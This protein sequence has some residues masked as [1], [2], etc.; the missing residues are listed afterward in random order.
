MTGL[1]I[2][3][4]YL[5]FISLGLP[6]SLLGSAWPS[7]YESMHSTITG[8]GTLAML[9]SACTI[10]SSLMA[11]RV[12]HRFGT[13]R[14]TTCSVAM[15]AC[16]LFGFSVSRS[17]LQL[18]FWC[19]PY[20]LGAGAVDSALNNYV[21]LHYSSR[22]M[23]WL[24]CMWGIG[25]SVG[26]WIMGLCLNRGQGW[27]MGYRI[28]GVL[29]VI[30]TVVLVVSFPLW[31]HASETEE[32]VHQV[33]PLKEAIRLPGAKP[34]LIAFLC[35]CGLEMTTGLWAASWLVTERGVNAVDAASYASLFYLGIT[36]GRA[37]S[38][39]ISERAGDE[40]MIRLGQSIV[41]VG[42]ILLF[43]NTTSRIGLVLI[44][45]GCAPI[46]PS[47]IHS[48]PSR[49]GKEH[50][51]S[52]VG[53]QMAFAYVGSTFAPKVFGVIS[54]WTGMRTY[55]LFLLLFL[56]LMSAMTETANSQTGGTDH[57]KQ[58]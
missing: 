13:A 2:A 41:L 11:D 53:I 33:L 42:V 15:T 17:Y 45:L 18:V 14:V 26:P 29:Q 44:G 34:I 52:L 23:S 28:I 30:L 38:G 46:Y 16:A 8:A 55:P 57:Q 43:L 27:P 49:F 35:Y 12:I 31:K 51:Q 21:A 7:M 20:G 10:V 25:A 1:L 5:A 37:F 3:V 24:H 32:E 40:K 54:E 22:H 39:L 56:I 36:I 58:K 48:T 6:D 4:I 19:I 50:S 47:I 9:I